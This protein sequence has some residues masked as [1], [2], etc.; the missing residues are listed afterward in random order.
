MANKVGVKSSVKAKVKKT[1]SNP[2]KAGAAREKTSGGIFTAKVIAIV[3]K[4][5]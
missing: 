4:K 3:N 1:S 5:K 2:V